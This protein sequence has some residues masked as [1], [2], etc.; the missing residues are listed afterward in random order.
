MSSAGVGI[1]QLVLQGKVL[2]FGF[3]SA[4]SGRD[5]DGTVPDIFLIIKN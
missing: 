5:S 1:A 4:V 2:S 3:G